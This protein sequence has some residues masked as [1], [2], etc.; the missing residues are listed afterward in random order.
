MSPVALPYFVK[1]AFGGG[2]VAGSD[3][4]ARR[5]NLDLPTITLAEFR[6]DAQAKF[7]AENSRSAELQNMLAEW[8]LGFDQALHIEAAYVAAGASASH[9]RAELLDRATGQVGALLALLSA[10]GHLPTADRNA[11]LATCAKLAGEVDRGLAS[12]TGGAA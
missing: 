10:L 11:T 7:V 12:L 2:S 1:R 6:V 5:A 9:A 3:W 8:N 4:L